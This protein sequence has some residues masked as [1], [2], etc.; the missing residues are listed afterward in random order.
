MWLIPV[1]SYLGDGISYPSRNYGLEIP[2]YK[3]NGNEMKILMAHY[4]YFHSSV[5]IVGP[6]RCSRQPRTGKY[7]SRSRNA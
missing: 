5:I 7:S 3:I 4:L 1:K 6:L 2:D